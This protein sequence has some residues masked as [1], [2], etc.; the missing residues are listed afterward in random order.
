M[1]LT[2][3]K[4]VNG[5]TKECIFVGHAAWMNEWKYFVEEKWKHCSDAN[6]LTKHQEFEVI[7]YAPA[8]NIGN[9]KYTDLTTDETVC[10]EA[11]GSHSF[12]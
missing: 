3:I 4:F 10:C 12:F 6:W 2:G 9:L 1:W 7:V 8:P 11:F 5:T